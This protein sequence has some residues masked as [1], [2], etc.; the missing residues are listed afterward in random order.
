MILRNL[1]LGA[2]TFT[3]IADGAPGI[4]RTLLDSR[5]RELE[6]AGVITRR[7]SSGPAGPDLRPD[8]GWQGSA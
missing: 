2:T 4:P 5:L 8:E 7:R 6:R 1:L 3:E